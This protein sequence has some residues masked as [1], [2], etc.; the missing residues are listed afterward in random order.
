MTCAEIGARIMKRA[1]DEP[2]APLSVTADPAGG[3]PKEILAAINEG[4][5]LAAML[6]LCLET[7]ANF[8]ATASTTFFGLRVT[9]PDYLV[10]LRVV[11]PTGRLRPSTLGDLDSL[12]DAWQSTV[13]APERYLAMGFN[14]F[15]LTPQPIAGTPL[16]ITYA[17]SPLQ[18]VGDDFP[19]IPE[20]Y[21]Q[22]LVEYGVYRVRLKEGAQSLQRGM[23]SL[24]RFLDEITAL[25]DYVRARSRAARY[26]VLPFEL[27]LFDRARLMQ[28]LKGKT[29][30]QKPVA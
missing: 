18:M 10:P 20:A 24:N 13:G 21:H 27:R 17:R 11:A 12:N 23:A 15:A 6:T 2:N 19:E 3:V 26:D 9:F 22:A 8:T 1:D 28:S 25:G 14:F 16:S 4:Q 30:W 5:E 7:T 29:P